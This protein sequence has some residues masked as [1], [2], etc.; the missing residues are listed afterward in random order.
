M[1]VD[2]EAVEFGCGCGV[3]VGV[4]WLSAFDECVRVD[5]GLLEEVG[6][7]CVFRSGGVHGGK[8]DAVGTVFHKV[9]VSCQDGG[10]GVLWSDFPTNFPVEYVTF[11]ILVVTGVIVDVDDLESS[12]RVVVEGDA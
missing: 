12:K 5:Y 11:V 8:V 4:V 2:V 6:L 1:V 10:V 3:F 9:E 7:T